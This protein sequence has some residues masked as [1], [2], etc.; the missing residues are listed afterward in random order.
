MK[1]LLLDLTHGGEVL[2]REYLRRGDEVT[3][4]DVYR[5]SSALAERLGAEGV[6]CLPA[7]P[8]ERFDLAVAPVHCPDRFM[9]LATADRRMTHHQA[10]GEMA[11]FAFPVAEVT[12]VRG[13]TSTVQ[14]LSFLMAAKGNKVLSLSSSGLSTWLAGEQVLEDK[15]SIAPP[16]MLRLSSL[17]Y[18]D[19]DLGIFEVSL[20]GT[21]LGKVSVIT[22]LQ[23]DYPIAA[24]TRRA[25][26]GKAQMAALARGTLVIPKQEEGT[27]RPLA[28]RCTGILTFGKDGDV[29]AELTSGP[30]GSPS[31]LR[32]VTD[33]GSVE[34]DLP[35]TYLASAYRLA[36]ACSLAAAQGL[37]H[38]PLALAPL[39][40]GF[41]G[42]R[43]RGEVTVDAKGELVRE[44]NPGVS[45]ASLDFLIRTL[46]D[47]HGCKDIGLVLD[48]VNRKVCEK[49][50]IDRIKEVCD[51]FPQVT[52][53]YVLPSGVD[54]GASH[55]FEP[56][57]RADQARSRHRT[58]L[59]A[60]KEGYL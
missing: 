47:E 4:V 57:E 53:R 9:G 19:H 36:F 41:R 35:A 54:I 46:V 13:K 25:Y 44:R 11:S 14:A 26:D 20:G 45:A 10:V 48:P 1:V 27:W 5:T 51:R 32:V 58:V 21:G 17:A 12:G 39:L 55:G 56:I 60:T 52:G 50:D 3:A 30:L 28:K 34:I 15:V 31:R 2:A 42:A 18:R 38:D 49:L 37:G 6:R 43:G 22:G 33:N 7:A 40:I 29:D 8:A 59:W 24:G 16:T 23:D